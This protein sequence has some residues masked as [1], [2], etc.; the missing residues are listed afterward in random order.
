VIDFIEELDELDNTIVIVMSDNG[1]SA[2]GGEHGTFNEALFFNGIDKTLEDNLKHID[3]WGGVD[4]YAHYSWGW[5]SAGNTPFRRW[6]ARNLSGRRHRPLH[7]QLA[8][9]HSCT[10]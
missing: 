4:T 8:R 6:K 9:W 2:E 3:D 5:T 10:R 7:R 1:A